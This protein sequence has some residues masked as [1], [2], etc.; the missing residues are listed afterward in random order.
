ME[1]RVFYQL[2]EER[3]DLKL[4]FSLLYFRVDCFFENDNGTRGEIVLESQIIGKSL[5]IKVLAERIDLNNF[6]SFGDKLEKL[7]EGTP[8][9]VVLDMEKVRF[10]DSSGL[11]AVMSFCKYLNGID[12]GLKVANCSSQVLT[13]FKLTELSDKIPLFDTVEDAVK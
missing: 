13:L 7:S 9:H 1:L 4:Y 3:V 6:D 2:F 10:L 12:R 8:G 5:V 11:G